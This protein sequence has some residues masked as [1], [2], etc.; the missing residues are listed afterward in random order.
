MNTSI[1][2]DVLDSALMRAGSSVGAAEAHGMVCGLLC[3]CRNM[4]DPNWL[5]ERLEHVPAPG[6]VLAG[7]AK[8]LLEQ[9]RVESLGQLNDPELGFE[10]LLPAEEQSL[11]AR[12]TALRDWCQ[13]FLS[14]FGTIPASNTAVLPDEVNELLADFVEITKVEADTDEQAEDEA[15]GSFVQVVEYVRMGV[16]LIYEELHPV[17]DAPGLQ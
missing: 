17:G 14:G 13:G 3:V 2:Y 4:D 10:L 1:D 7:E 8:E 12:V 11:Y 9:L 5:A 15:E 16:L 6:D